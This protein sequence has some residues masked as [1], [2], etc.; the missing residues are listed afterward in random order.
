MMGVSSEMDKSDWF[1]RVLPDIPK[2]V[3]VNVLYLFMD[4]DVSKYQA[5][6]ITP[7]L[8]WTAA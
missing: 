1:M 3:V 6:K 8:T 2:N 4:Q 7:K 5:H